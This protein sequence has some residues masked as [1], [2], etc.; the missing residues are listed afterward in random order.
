MFNIAAV[1][2]FKGQAILRMKLESMLNLLR[3][4]PLLEHLLRLQMPTLSAFL[5]A[6]LASIFF[7]VAPCASAEGTETIY[8]D[9]YSTIYKQRFVTDEQARDACYA[10]AQNF[11]YDRS[12]CGRSADGSKGIYTW[13]AGWLRQGGPDST[14]PNPQWALLQ[15]FYC[16]ADQKYYVDVDRCV[17]SVSVPGPPDPGESGPPCV[18]CDKT[19]K[20]VGQP[21]NPAT[22]NMWHTEV[23]YAAAEPSPLRIKRTYNSMRYKLPGMGGRGFGAN[24]SQSYDAALRPAAAFVPGVRYVQCWKR[25]DNG[26]VWC[27]TDKVEQDPIPKAVSINRGDGKQ[28]VF[29]KSEGNLWLSRSDSSDRVTASYSADGLSVTEW[30]YEDARNQTIERFNADGWLISIAGKNGRIQKLTYST[31]ATNDTSVA[32]IPVD[33]P[34]CANV[35]SGELLRVGELVCVTDN[36]GRQLQFEYN[37]A[38]RIAKAIDPGGKEYLYTYDGADNVASVTFPDG[39]TKTYQYNEA[40]RINGGNACSNAVQT[41]TGYRHLVN[42]MT[43]ITDEN[44][45]RYISWTYD[46]NGLATSSQKAGGAEKISLT[47]YMD[48][49]AGTSTVYIAYFYGK[50]ADSTFTQREYRYKT[51]GSVMKNISVSD[52]CPECGPYKSRSY[53]ANGN[54]VSRTDWKGNISNYT[55]DLAANL[56]TSRTEAVGT[57]Q[58]RTISTAWDAALRRPLKIAEPKRITTYTY[59]AAGNVLKRSLQATTDA[60]GT[61]GF[62]AVPVGQARVWTYTYNDLGQTLSLTGPRMDLVNST[63]FTYQPQSGMLASVRNALGHTTTFSEYDGNGRPGRID[64][65]N[66]TTTRLTYT[67][68]GLLSKNAVSA[69]GIVQTTSYGYDAAGQLKNV[70][71]PDGSTLTYGYDD[72][73]RLISISDAIGNSIRYTLGVSGNRLGETTVD[74]NGTLVRA[75]ARVY[76]SLDY[77]QKVTGA[78]Q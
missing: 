6:F 76:D 41:G 58:A 61:L 73:H 70:T 56:Q 4:R 34:S 24:W 40:T 3:T 49:V 63:V 51:V 31:G 47:Y 71:Q 66:G 55:Y 16:P 46:C 14:I 9:Q 43:G 75:I 8:V 17:L 52:A 29:N 38:H 1:L 37:A 72:A 30:M 22:G 15:Y 33:A 50:P 42:T 48:A 62:A 20:H 12:Y 28:Y 44:G 57:A 74:Q 18:E 10:F 7:L 45:V 65:A 67:D 2:L 32:R 35:Q 54:D 36:W 78:A 77:L 26:E 60:G 25:F 59:D 23:D 5:G 53:D 21:I 69:G 11:S 13:I 27:D 19:Q 39:K 68:R 64:S